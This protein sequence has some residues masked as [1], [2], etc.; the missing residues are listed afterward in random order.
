MPRSRAT[1]P[2]WTLDALRTRRSLTLHELAAA[3][4]V[5]RSTGWRAAHG[6]HFP[7]PRVRRA[8]ATA[9]GTS[10]D[11]IVWTAQEATHGQD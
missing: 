4:G 5:S 1:T 6:V 7:S 10:P 2:Q 3:A 9:L 8:L 11:R